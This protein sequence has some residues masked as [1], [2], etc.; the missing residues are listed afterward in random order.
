M[1]FELI[2]NLKKLCQQ[3]LIDE[4]FIEKDKEY[5]LDTIDFLTF[6]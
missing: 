4:Y 2:P 6:I 1:S 5:E 3:L